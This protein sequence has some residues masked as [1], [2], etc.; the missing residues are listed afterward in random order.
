MLLP[1]DGGASSSTRDAEAVTHAQVAC[2]ESQNIMLPCD[3]V[4]HV[5]LGDRSE[6]DR[7]RPER[8]LTETLKC[9]PLNPGTAVAP[10]SLMPLISD[11]VRCLDQ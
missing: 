5:R 7:Y 8:K 6:H 9:Q 1:R 10:L 4:R 11:T 2:R 3:Y